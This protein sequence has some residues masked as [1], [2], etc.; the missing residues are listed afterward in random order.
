MPLLTSVLILVVLAAVEG[1]DLTLTEDA[2]GQEVV[3]A[4]IDR[5]RAQCIFTDDRFL[6]RRLAFVESQ[7]GEAAETYSDGYH[8][9]IWKVDYDMFANTS[10]CAQPIRNTCAVIKSSFGFDWTRVWWSDL[11]KPLYSG[12]GAVLFILSQNLSFLPADTVSQ[13]QFWSTAYRRGAYMNKY[14]IAAQQIRELGCSS[15]LDLAFILD[16]SGSI[17]QDEFERV[18]GFVI[19]IARDF[20]ISKQGVQLA[21]VEFSSH[22]GDVIHLNRYC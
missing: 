10:A 22:V 21:V 9:G 7:D 3:E 8:G 1:K 5:I 13:A 18:K 16:G 2:S 15:E 12:L 20:N 14:I 6:L 4:V 17:H 19:N 11:R